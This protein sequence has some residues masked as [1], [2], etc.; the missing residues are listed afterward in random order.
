MPRC[1]PGGSGLPQSALL[2]GRV[3]HGEV[4]GML[5]HQ[6]AAELELSLPAARATSSMKHSM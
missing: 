6:R 2:G 5:A 3:E 4:L 1:T